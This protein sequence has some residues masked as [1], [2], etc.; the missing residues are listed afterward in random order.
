MIKFPTLKKK[1]SKCSKCDIFEFLK[2]IIGN[3]IKTSSYKNVIQKKELSSNF[4]SMES[5]PSLTHCI[6]M[7]KVCGSSSTMCGK[8]LFSSS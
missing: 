3:L 4:F 1:G 6:R 5:H 2:L 8:N 7:D